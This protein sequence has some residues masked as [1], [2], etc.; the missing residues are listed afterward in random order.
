MASSRSCCATPDRNSLDFYSGFLLGIKDLEND[1]TNIDLNV[2]DCA[3]SIPISSEKMDE[4][5]MIF[6]PITTLQLEKVA[7][8]KKSNTMLIS[9]LD[10][11]AEKLAA[12]YSNFI[13]VPP[14]SDAQYHDIAR[15]VTEDFTAGDNVITIYEKNNGK[16]NIVHFNEIIQQSGL[17]SKFFSYTILEGRTLESRLGNELTQTGTN[18]I[19][20]NSENEAFVNDVIRN[21]NILLHKKNQI[22]IYC[23]SKIRSFD[24]VDIENLH[25]LNTHMAGSYH[26]DYDD[27]VTERFVKRYRALYNSEPS[28]F[29]FQGYDLATYFIGMYSRYGI[30]WTKH[31]E[32]DKES[33]RQLTFDFRQNENGSFINQGTRRFIYEAD[34]KIRMVR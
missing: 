25:N 7:M 17:N 21:L 27:P 29:A 11:R 6:G 24:T 18:R 5:Q 14:G 19:I 3:Q 31:L 1:V 13:Q 12:T 9:P 23:S 33:L 10:P 15:W 4:S 30:R 22:V 32:T 8:M 20:I 26:A 2:Y 28:Q 16:Q 34:Y